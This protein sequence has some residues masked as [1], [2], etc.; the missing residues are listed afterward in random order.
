MFI[1][2]PKCHYLNFVHASKSIIIIIIK[3]A[4]KNIKENKLNKNQIQQKEKPQKYFG[5]TFW[6]TNLWIP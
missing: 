4:K 3:K 6:N 5:N 1:V 2:G